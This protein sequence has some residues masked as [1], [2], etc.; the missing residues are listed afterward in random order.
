[1][2]KVTWLH[3]SDLHL[4][5]DETAIEKDQT[6]KLKD[7]I[8]NVI[9]KENINLDAVFFNGDI[10]FSG[11]RHQYQQAI[12]WF[13]DILDSCGLSR[14]RD[15]LFIVPGNHDVDRSKV[16][17]PAFVLPQYEDFARALLD[18]EINY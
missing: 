8:S 1:M 10:A 5:A 17:K 16:N 3:L 18:T 12:S 14:Q 6:T 11:Q 2:D 13:D 15:K 4:K 9:A 7:D